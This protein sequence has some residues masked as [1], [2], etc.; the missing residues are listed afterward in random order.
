MDVRLADAAALPRGDA[1]ADLAVAFMLL[2]DIDAMPT[3]VREVA[4]VLEPGAGL[5]S[6]SC[7]TRAV[8][9][10][11]YGFNGIDRCALERATPSASGRKPVLFYIR[12]RCKF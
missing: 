1:S 7:G 12:L 5:R 10:V 11:R 2:Q 3:A 9:S 8:T 6:F 4:R